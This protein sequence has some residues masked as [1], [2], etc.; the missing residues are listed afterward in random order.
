MAEPLDLLAHAAEVRALQVAA[1][2]TVAV[3]TGVG[4]PDDGEPHYA[5]HA[6][7]PG[8]RCVGVRDA[9][10]LV[11][12][13]YGMT[14]RAGSWWD[15][16]VRGAMTDAGRAGLL[17][18]A[19]EV[20]AVHVDPRHH[21]RGAGRDLVTSLLAGVDHPRALLTTQGGSNPARGFYRRLGFA[22]LPVE[23]PYDD[24]PFVV[25]TAELPLGAQ[26]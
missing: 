7:R 17:D 9:D 8:F 24:V 20:V 5:Q 25:L 19:F 16:W 14:A 15:T 1:L 6:Q 4:G 13:A 22:E 3:A 23:V 2:R 12:F 18:G 11:G 21:G 26:P 10:R